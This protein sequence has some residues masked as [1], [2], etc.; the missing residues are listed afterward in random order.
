MVS[1]RGVIGPVRPGDGGEDWLLVGDAAGH[2]TP[3]TGEGIR[4][5]LVGGRLAA[6]AILE[7]KPATWRDRWEAAFG[8][9]LRWAVRLV[10]VVERCGVHGRWMRGASGS[11]FLT[12]ALDDLAFAR[13]PCRRF[14]LAGLWRS[15]LEMALPAW[16]R[17][18][19]RGRA[20]PRPGDAT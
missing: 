1:L 12:Q 14:V 10:E 17:G 16:V 9:E 18:R 5:A 20:T 4:F 19:S 13:V 11:R 15:F 3:I 7:G 8:D 2:V 6:E